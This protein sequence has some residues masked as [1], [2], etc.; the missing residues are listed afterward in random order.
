MMLTIVRADVSFAESL[1]AATTLLVLC[2]CRWREIL[3]TARANGIKQKALVF[4][5]GGSYHEFVAT[6]MDLIWKDDAGIVRMSRSR[7]E[8][9]MAEFGDFFGQF[10]AGQF[11]PDIARYAPSRRTSKPD[12]EKRYNEVLRALADEA[13][14]EDFRIAFSA[15]PLACWKHWARGLYSG[16]QYTDYVRIQ[17]DDVVFNCGVHGGSELEFYLAHL[18]QRGVC[19]NIDPLGHKYLTPDVSTAIAQ[20]PATI[21]EIAAALHDSNGTLNLPVEASGM[22]AGNRIDKRIEGAPLQEFRAVTLDF[23]AEELSIS[24]LDHIKMD[25]EGAEER[26]LNGAINTVTRFRPNLAIS[27]YHTPDQFLDI[28]IYL[29]RSLKGY[30]FFVR[31][32]HFISNETILY[33]IPKERPFLPRAKP[34]DV[35]LS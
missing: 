16:L 7:L 22:A 1:G 4:P 12:A 30:R 19:V 28:P 21:I 33:C 9:F 35:Q 27:I 29:A 3:K 5:L 15:E 10:K 2:G 20:S 34:I 24:R 13:S 18:G 32:Y 6:P 11:Q 14:L 17:P 25:I 8:K 23:L 31:N 26:A